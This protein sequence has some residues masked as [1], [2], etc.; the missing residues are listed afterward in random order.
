MS[1]R[2]AGN[3]VPVPPTRPRVGALLAELH[4]SPTERSTAPRTGRRH[5]RDRPPPPLLRGAAL[6]HPQPGPVV[7][8][9]GAA[10]AR[11]RRSERWHRAIR[12]FQRLSRPPHRPMCSSQRPLRPSHRP[13]R[14]SQRPLCPSHRPVRSSERPLRPSH[15]PVRSSQRPL[16]PSHRP[17]RSCSE[18]YSDPG[19][20]RLRAECRAERTPRTGG[21]VVGGRRGPA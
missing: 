3:P 14:S 18:D 9:R 1:G 20:T 17:V 12:P 16:R 19:R 13:V 11:L 15:R 10:R 8:S 2:W 7:C 4:G 6:V 21:T 5:V